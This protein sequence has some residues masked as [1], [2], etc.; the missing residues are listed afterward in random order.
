MYTLVYNTDKKF[1]LPSG[2]TELWVALNFI[3]VAMIEYTSL[4]DAAE[5]MQNEDQVIDVY[6]DISTP[7]LCDEDAIDDMVLVCENVYSEA[8]IKPV[9]LYSGDDLVWK[10]P[11]V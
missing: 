5:D 10:A 11:L 8:D 1:D 2:I 3:S 6:S 9:A 7:P 4:E